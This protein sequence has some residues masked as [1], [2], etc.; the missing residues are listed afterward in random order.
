M[1]AFVLIFCW[2]FLIR[3]IL[4]TPKNLFKSIYFEKQNKYFGEIM[5]FKRMFPN[6]LDSIVNVS[7][8]F[9]LLIKLISFYCICWVAIQYRENLYIVI[10]STLQ[11]ASITSTLLRFPTVV[12]ELKTSIK[13]ESLKEVKFMRWR[14]LYDVFKDYAFYPVVIFLLMTT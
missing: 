5:K 12:H 1:K 4:D 7:L 13:E 14:N 6:M 3:A 8:G 10:A 11:I 2:F 9:T